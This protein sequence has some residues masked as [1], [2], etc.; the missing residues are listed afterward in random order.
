[1]LGLFSSHHDGEV[2][3]AA[4]K[5]EAMRRESGVSWPE[6]VN[7]KFKL[8]T[9][10]DAARQL[11]AENEELR[12]ELARLREA[13]QHP[14]VPQPWRDAESCHDGAAACL[15]W[16]DHLTDWETSFLQSLLRRRKRLTQ[17]Q[18][19]VLTEIGE[20]VDRYLGATWAYRQRRSAA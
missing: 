10:T 15:L 9:A 20:K 7:G 12:N 3:A 13:L 19:A 8:A 4:R 6:L 5:A 2:L 11:L 16:S 18:V 14:P 17:K 1:V